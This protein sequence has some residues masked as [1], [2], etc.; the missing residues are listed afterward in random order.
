MLTGLSAFWFE[1]RPSRSAQPPR[2][3]HR[4]ARRDTRTRDARRAARD[5]PR[6]VRGA[7]VHHRLGLEGLPV[8][9]RGLRDRAA[10]RPARVR[11]AAR[12]DLHARDQGRARRSRRERGLRP[13]GRDRRRPGA[14]RGAAPA[15]DRD[16]RPRRRHARER[17]IILADTKFEFG[18]RPD[19]TIVL[20]DEVLTPDSSRFWPADGYE[21][22][23][24]QPSFDKQYVRD[25][26]AGSGWDKSPPAPPLPDDVVEGTRARYQEAYERITG[27]PF[28]AWLG[29]LRRLTAR[30]LIRPKEGI[31]DP[32]GQAVERALTALGFAG[33]VGRAGGAAHRAA[34]R[35][36]GTRP[37]DV[38]APA[39]QPADRGLRGGRARGRGRV[40]FGVLRFPG[41]C[42]E[43]DALLACRRYAEADLHL[44][45]RPR[46][47]R[48]GR[49]GGPGRLLLRGLPA[50]RG[51]RPLLPGDGGG[52][53]LRARGR[54]R[55]RHL[56]RLPGALRGRAPARRAAPERV[57][58]LRLPPGGRGGGPRRHSVHACE[59]GGRGPVDPRQAHH[60]ALLRAGD[61]LRRARGERTGGA[62]LRRRAEPERVDAE[63][64]RRL[65]PGTGT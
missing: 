10:V 60:R 32:S 25:W 13:C 27:E 31:L 20:G 50:R 1:R 28:G 51:D 34:G 15:L 49:R 64:G 33:R 65:Q 56:Q 38:R 16:L 29:A 57:A 54:A 46:P 36:P 61:H 24:G 14:A 52:R 18:R 6:R 63:H 22:G 44:A 53:R 9:R 55:A 35:R 62:P 48:R 3:V 2:L 43:V 8:H 45:R 5:G 17:G 40:R 4:R 30:V 42:D 21:P 39:R 37:G 47:R 23:H 12:A 59:P 58:P 11:A 41:S 19:G 7:R 26:A